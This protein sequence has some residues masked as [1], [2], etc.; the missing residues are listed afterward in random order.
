MQHPVFDSTDAGDGSLDHIRNCP[1]AGLDERIAPI[2]KFDAQD[3]GGNH[4]SGLSAFDGDR[5]GRRIGFREAIAVVR[6]RG[7][8]ILGTAESAAARIESLDDD[9]RRSRNGQLRFESGVEGVDDRI[10]GEMTG[11]GSQGHPHIHARA[12]PRLIERAGAAQNLPYFK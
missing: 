5:S 4:I 8:H 9:L 11:I 6:R 12:A 1:E 10:G 2:P 3:F 7:L